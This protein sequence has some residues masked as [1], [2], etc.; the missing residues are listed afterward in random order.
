M[1]ARVTRGMMLVAALSALFLAVVS[2]VAAR[3]LWQAAAER[4]LMA[5]SEA[6]LAAT[7]REAQDDGLGP[8]EC[9]S[10]PTGQAGECPAR[11]VSHS[12]RADAERSER[13]RDLLRG[14]SGRAWS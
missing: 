10:A 5:A 13:K 12:R 3:L 2:S 6:I 7:A 14:Q 1:A 8:T 4:D 9:A 11:D